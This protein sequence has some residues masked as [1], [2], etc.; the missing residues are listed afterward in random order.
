MLIL[1]SC[2][3]SGRREEY[4]KDHKLFVSF[5][6]EEKSYCKALPSLTSVSCFRELGHAC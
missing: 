2:V 6:L 3:Q 5:V 1:T 4:S